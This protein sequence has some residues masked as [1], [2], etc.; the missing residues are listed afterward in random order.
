MSDTKPRTQAVAETASSGSS[1]LEKFVL[2]FFAFVFAALIAG[3]VTYYQTERR[4][5]ADVT[6]N[7]DNSII[8]REWSGRTRYQNHIIGMQNRTFNEFT[9]AVGASLQTISALTWSYDDKLGASDLASRV[10]QYRRARAR[11]QTSEIRL[12]ALIET[13]FGSEVRDEFEFGISRELDELGADVE[14]IYLDSLRR[15][16]SSEPP[17]SGETGL[18]LRS[19]YKDLELRIYTF[20]VG[21]LGD[22]K[23]G[24]QTYGD[25]PP[26]FTFTPP[27]TGTP[28]ELRGQVE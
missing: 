15:A 18:A 17:V 28:T 20:L 4:I 1:F 16:Q 13:Y 5:L 3:G 14:R 6:A 10:D 11:W 23:S 9:D 2:L 22:I 25:I 27:L 8:G 24:Y 7:A 26:S 12:R 21:M 19:R